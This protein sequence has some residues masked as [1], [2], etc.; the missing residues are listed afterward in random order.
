[1]NFIKL[2]NK[3]IRFLSKTLCFIFILILALES[4]YDFLQISAIINLSSEGSLIEIVQALLLLLSFL[5]TIKNRKLILKIS[6]KL[7]FLA[8]LIFIF[9]LFYEEV[10]FLSSKIIHF[11]NALNFQN[12]INIHNLNFFEKNYFNFNIDYINLSFSI[13]F[14]VIF[15]CIILFTLCYGLYFPSLKKYRMFFLEKKYSSFFIL[16]FLLRIISSVS[17]NSFSFFNGNLLIS[18]EFLE[19]LFYIIIFKDTIDKLHI[20]KSIEKLQ[21]RKKL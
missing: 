11:N 1:M 13:S 14:Q 18:H 7:V 21:P 5:L 4:R 2:N 20:F 17:I 16:Y 6:S 15:Y 8:R 19:L 12:E 3:N 9:L 10:S